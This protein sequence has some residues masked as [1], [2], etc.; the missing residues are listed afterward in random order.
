M[1]IMDTIVMMDSIYHSAEKL[2]K[3]KFG[4]IDE[5]IFSMDYKIRS[6]KW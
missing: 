2:C 3:N 4:A 1:V 5:N 6:K